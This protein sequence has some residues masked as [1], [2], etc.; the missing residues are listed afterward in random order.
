MK[1]VFGN[2][3]TITLFG[4]RQGAKIGA[5]VDGL[6]PG[7]DVDLDF[8]RKQLN[9][10]KPHGK[11]STQRVETDEPQ[12]VSGVFEGKTTGTPICILSTPGINVAS[13]TYAAQEV[14][15]VNKVSFPSCLI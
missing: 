3:I 9:L 15:V 7:L 8:M 11:I 10:R 4:E 5:V 13:T 14:V 2:Q 6:A 12:I 1:N